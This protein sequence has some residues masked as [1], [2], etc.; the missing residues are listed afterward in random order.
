M[1][2]QHSRR[3]GGR[4]LLSRRALRKGVEQ[5]GQVQSAVPGHDYVQARRVEPDLGKGPRPAEQARELE[6]DE[7]TVEAEQW[8]PVGLLEPEVLD[9]E[10]EQERVEPDPADLRAPIELLLHVS[11]HVCPDQAGHQEEAGDRVHRGK[12]HDDGRGDEERDPDDQ[13][14]EASPPMARAVRCRQ[15]DRHRPPSSLGCRTSQR[16]RQLQAPDSTQRECQN[17]N[18]IKPERWPEPTP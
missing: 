2:Q 6:V 11:G 9:L 16:S 13:A 18:V 15:R 5:V 3:S 12:E 14:P 7:Q 4:R 1:L 17:N 10:L 8:A